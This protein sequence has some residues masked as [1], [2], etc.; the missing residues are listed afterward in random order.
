[1]L[2]RGLYCC[3][4]CYILYVCKINEIKNFFLIKRNFLFYLF[5][6]YIKCD[7]FYNSVGFYIIYIFFIFELCMNM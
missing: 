3:K 2:Y 7:I 5:C 1:M 4:R 6:I